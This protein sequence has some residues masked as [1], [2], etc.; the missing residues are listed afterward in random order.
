[1]KSTDL[2][3]HGRFLG[4]RIFGREGTKVVVPRGAMELVSGVDA[5]VNPHSAPLLAAFGV[6]E[7]VL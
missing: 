1:M 4:K 6:E 2:L 3:L 7:T 5:L